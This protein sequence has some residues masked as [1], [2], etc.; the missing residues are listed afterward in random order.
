MHVGK[1]DQ[2]PWSLYFYKINVEL[3]QTLLADYI[4]ISVD[5]LVM[6]SNMTP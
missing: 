1:N 4:I 2:I 6:F 5:E 3:K